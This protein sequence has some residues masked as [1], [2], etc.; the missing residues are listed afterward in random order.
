[1]NKMLIFGA[2]IL[3]TEAAIIWANVK[4]CY[5]FKIKVTNHY[6]FTA[7]GF[8]KS[9]MNTSC[10]G[11]HAGETASNRHNADPIFHANLINL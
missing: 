1:M 8:G 6:H 2:G 4:E 5:A 11:F 9:R 3:K 10:A 7:L